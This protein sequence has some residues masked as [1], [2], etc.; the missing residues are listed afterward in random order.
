MD[1]NIFAPGK[2][3]EPYDFTADKGTRCQLCN[4]NLLLAAVP[5]QKRPPPTQTGRLQGA[6]RRGGCRV[7][8]PFIHKPPFA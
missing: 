4:S 5:C 1:I 7:S 2:K 8:G 3:D 6:P